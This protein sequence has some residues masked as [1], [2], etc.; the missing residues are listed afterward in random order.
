MQFVI[1]FAAAQE[2]LT[3]EKTVP[4]KP[5][6]SNNQSNSELEDLFK[7]TPLVTP[8]SEK[9]QKDLKNDIMSLFEKVCAAFVL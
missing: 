2:S 7:D 8:S 3:A 6:E 5:V 4:A 1:Q 9:P